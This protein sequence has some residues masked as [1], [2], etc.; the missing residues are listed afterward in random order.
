MGEDGIKKLEK[1]SVLNMSLKEIENNLKNLQN[2][3][4]G[5]VTGFK[6]NLTETEKWSS[7]MAKSGKNSSDLETEF[8][9][10]TESVK[11]LD[12]QKDAFKQA[13][14]GMTQDYRAK[15]SE[16]KTKLKIV[17]K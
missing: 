14:E 17:K 9:A 12:M 13:F 5:L 4:D 10:K 11:E 16:I 6:N 2:D 8:N 3:T 7:E 15:I 1:D